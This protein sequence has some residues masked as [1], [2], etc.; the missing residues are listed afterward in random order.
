MSRQTGNTFL[1]ILYENDTIN[2]TNRDNHNLVIVMVT[3]YIFCI[4]SLGVKTPQYLEFLRILLITFKL[5][6]KFVK[7][8]VGY[9]SV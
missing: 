6:N 2:E 1:G 5:S 8:V 7:F 3:T 4:L 9:Q